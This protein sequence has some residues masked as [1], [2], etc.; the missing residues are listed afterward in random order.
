MDIIVC[1]TFIKRHNLWCQTQHYPFWQ[2]RERRIST[3][4]LS[5]VEDLTLK[6]RDQVSTYPTR[7][8]GQGFYLWNPIWKSWVSHERFVCPIYVGVCAFKFNSLILN[9]WTSEIFSLFF[10]L[11]ATTLI[12]TWISSS[13]FCYYC[14][15]SISFLAL[16][17]HPSNL[18]FR[19]F[20][21]YTWQTEWSVTFGFFPWL[22]L[23]VTII[24]IVGS[25]WISTSHKHQP[26]K[27]G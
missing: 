26:P 14:L 21:L 7:L 24:S 1:C 11:D 27:K 15:Q 22:V 18:H 23:K 10:Y 6:A 25:E 13:A 20:P 12:L 8:E 5:I 9:V 17:P 4:H 16:L 19:F 2:Q 3:E